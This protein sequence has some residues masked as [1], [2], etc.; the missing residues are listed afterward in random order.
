MGQIVGGI[1]GSGGALLGGIGERQNAEAAKKAAKFNAKLA[2]REGFREEAR[3]RSVGRRE[4]SENVT[5]V[6]KSGVRLEGSPLEVLANNAALVEAEALRARQAG[7][8]ANKLFRMQAHE[9]RK[10]EGMALV[11]GLINSGSSAASS[12]GGSG[13]GAAGAQQSPQSAPS[14]SNSSARLD[15]VKLGQGTGYS[16]NFSGFGRMRGF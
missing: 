12:F 7:L 6:A 8:L 4:A 3:I 16:S 15:R 5:R 1:L 2:R 10:A 13:G 14:Y 9:A 11:G